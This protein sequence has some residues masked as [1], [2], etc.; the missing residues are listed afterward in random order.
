MLSP[1][2][3]IYL[4]IE[5][6]LFRVH[7]MFHAKS[8]NCIHSVSHSKFRKITVLFLVNAFIAFFLRLVPSSDTDFLFLYQCHAGSLLLSNRMDFLLIEWERTEQNI[9]S[10]MEANKTRKATQLRN[11]ESVKGLGNIHIIY[12]MTR[13]K[14]FSISIC[15]FYTCLGFILCVTYVVQEMYTDRFQKILIKSCSRP[16]TMKYFYH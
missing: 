12:T 16:S 8:L 13:S 3:S 2:Q 14:L 5:K 4:C 1:C 15:V 7:V 11:D 9:K 6:W 10:R